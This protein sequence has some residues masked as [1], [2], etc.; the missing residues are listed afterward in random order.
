MSPELQVGYIEAATIIDRRLAGSAKRAVGPQTNTI[1]I[2]LSAPA[3]ERVP[4]VAVGLRFQERNQTNQ[5]RRMPRRA[6]LRFDP[7]RI[8]DPFLC[9]VVLKIVPLSYTAAYR[10]MPL[11]RIYESF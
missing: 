1:G 6:S 2:E 11:G 7:D 4:T 10:L 3:F 9:P 5:V 8:T